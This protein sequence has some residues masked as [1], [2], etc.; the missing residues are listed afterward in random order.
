MRL[1]TS[2][3]KFLILL[4]LGRLPVQD[5]MVKVNS[6]CLTKHHAMKTFWGVVV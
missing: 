2:Q 3:F 4:R 6:L 1:C 5:D